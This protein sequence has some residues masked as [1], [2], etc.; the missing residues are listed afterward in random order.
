MDCDQIAELAPGNPD[1]K[2]ISKTKA[3]MPRPASAGEGEGEIRERW[4]RGGEGCAWRDSQRDGG[5]GGWE[6]E[7]AGR[8]P[9][10]SQSQGKAGWDK[11]HCFIAAR[12]S[13]AATS[14]VPASEAAGR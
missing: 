3:L 7:R 13:G 12:S 10:V 8:S 11:H 2:T 1:P 5:G 14:A 9:G 4:V 6:G